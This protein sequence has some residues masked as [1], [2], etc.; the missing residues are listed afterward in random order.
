MT[1]SDTAGLDAFDKA[2]PHETCVG[3]RAIWMH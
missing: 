1:L 2:F 3:R